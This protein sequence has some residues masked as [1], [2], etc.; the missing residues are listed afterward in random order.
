MRRL[1]IGLAAALAL[2]A[3]PATQ[4]S[5]APTDPFIYQSSFDGAGIGGFGNVGDIAINRATGN[6]LV[7][8]GGRIDQFDASGNP[9]DFSATGSPSLQ[10]GGNGTVAVDNSG[11]PTQGNIYVFA[12]NGFQS[13]AEYFWAFGPGG[14]PLAANPQSLIGETFEGF[15]ASVGVGPDGKLWGFYLAFVGVSHV[16]QMTIGGKAAGVDIAIPELGYL[17]GSPAIADGLGNFYLSTSGKVDRFDSAN[18]FA[19]MGWTGLPAGNTAV[20]PSTNDVY[21]RQGGKIFGVHYS[22]PLVTS[23]P[24]V[25]LS[26]VSEGGAIVFDNSGETLYVAEGSRISVFHREPPSVPSGLGHLVV[27]GVRTARATLHGQVFAAGSPTSYHFEYGT[28]TTYGT[29][30]PEVQAPFSHFEA[31]KAAALVEGLAPDT[32]YH[33]RIVATNSAGTTYGPDKV[34]TTYAIPP[35]GVDSCPNAL[36]RKQTSA[37]DLPDCRAYELVSARSTGG[38]E[39]ESSLVS[40]QTPFGGYPDAKGRVLYGVHAGTI[41]G[42]WHA[43]NRGVDPYV[44]TRGANGWSTDYLGLPSDINSAS[45]PFSSS[46]GEADAGLDTLAFTGSGL[47]KPCFDSGIETGIPVRLPGGQLVQGMAGSLDPGVPG[48]LPE[49][50][51]GKYFSADGQHLVFASK[52]AFE[53]GAND[54]SGDLTVYERDLSAGETEIVSTTAGGSVMTGP[55]ISELDISSD[56]SRVIFGQ[57]VSTDSAGNEYLHPYLHLAGLQGSVDLAPTTTSGVLYD[58]MSSDGSKVF[59]TTKDALLPTD[60]TDSSAD[61][62]EADVDGD[63][64]VALSLIS[65]GNSTACNP[66]ANSARAHWN[67]VSGT[68]DCGAVAVG[69]GGGVASQSGAVYFLS[70]EQLDGSEG[71]LDQPNLYLTAPGGTP[72]F[73]ATLEPNNPLVLDSVGAAGTHRSADFQTNP[74]GSDAAFTSK[75]QLSPIDPTGDAQVFHYDAASDALSCASCNPTNSQSTGAS[76]DAL[77]APDGRSITDDGRVFFSTPIPLVLRDT[78]NRLDVYE[79]SGGPAQLISSGISPFDSGLLSVSSDGTDAYFFTHDRLAAAEDQN[80]GTV[81][82]IY[83]ARE[84]GGFFAIPGPGPCAAS[85][86]CHGPGTQSAPAPPIRTGGPS[87]PGNQKAAPKAQSCRK[88]QAKKRGRCVAKKKS[89]AKKHHT[90][91]SQSKSRGSH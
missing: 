56:G 38:Y 91:K 49:G 89:H 66:V 55:G 71:T 85:D 67:S 72:V 3:I 21:A 4:A 58:G 32:T 46:L 2:A 53:P 40:G 81:T 51:V 28:D 79:S 60:D 15:T 29:S 8:E 11:G 52:Y 39:V 76:G 43:T 16:G 33:V 44:A 22:D 7:F 64:N 27:D 77:L 90:T 17:P 12:P 84:K 62:Y 82:R 23:T 19:D 25:G 31:V 65:A 78:G 57:K 35:G 83:D 68:A 14:E 74:S 88:G 13:G 47:C 45:G 87:I 63:G 18:N 30:T 10:V 9:V 59:F 41:P 26:D 1:L 42:P 73:I 5:A 37:R 69:G 75:L 34:F 86:E 20:D 50:K 6:L 48:A 61:I 24:F 36:A 54:N 80:S 70:P